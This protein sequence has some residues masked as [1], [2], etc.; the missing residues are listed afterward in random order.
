MIRIVLGWE[1]RKPK[2][3][4]DPKVLFCGHSK[5]GAC[6]A[7]DEALASGKFG[8]VGLQTGVTPHFKRP[9]SK[10]QIAA[11]E[12]REAKAKAEEEAKAKAEEEAKAKAEEEAKAKAEEEA[13]AKASSQKP[14]PNNSGKKTETK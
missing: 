4:E 3:S 2:K 7:R 12:A 8:V 9:P 10:D 5:S 6:E 14:K 11:N 13:K 1:G